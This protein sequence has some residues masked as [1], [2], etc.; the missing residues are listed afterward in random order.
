MAN[1]MML[2]HFSWVWLATAVSVATVS[3]TLV[4][5]RKTYLSIP[6]GQRWVKKGSRSEDL[7]LKTLASLTEP[8]DFPFFYNWGS[9][10]ATMTWLSTLT[11]SFQTH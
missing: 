4:A 9:G 8:E 1:P 11:G 10:N 3:I 7:V 2:N 5:I 6:E